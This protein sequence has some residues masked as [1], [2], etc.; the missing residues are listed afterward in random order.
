MASPK[1]PSSAH[2]F[3]IVDAHHHF[4]D[5]RRNYHPWL[6]DDPPIAFRYGDYSAIRRPYLSEH[7]L[8]DAKDYELRGSVYVETEWDPAHPVDEM[9]YVRELRAACGLPSVAVAAAWLHE[10]RTAS[11]L[12]SYLEFDFV[13]GVRHK[14]PPGAMTSSEWRRGF[15]ELVRRGLRYDLQAPWAQLSDAISLAR[16]F[17]EARIIINHAGLPADRSQAALSAWAK[18]MRE[19]SR[20]PNIAIKISGIGQQGKAWTAQ[21]NREIVLTLIECFGV[22]RCMFASNFPVD[23]LCASFSQ[24]FG[25]FREIVADFTDLERRALFGGNAVRLYDIAVG[26]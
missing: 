2:P 14:P 4:W 22:E 13:R 3:P 17:D 9:R 10:S 8:A 19:L 25:G 16:D 26:I 15:A 1:A 23:S 5:P 24:I 7:Y 11:L 21:A 6:C 18:V 20:C 12:E